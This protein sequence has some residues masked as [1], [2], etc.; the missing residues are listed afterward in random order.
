MNEVVRVIGQLDDFTSTLIR[1]LTLEATANLIE[2][3]PVDTGWA[4]ANWVPRIGTPFE[5]VSGTREQ[6]E[7]GN[8]VTSDR[9]AGIAQIAAQYQIRDGAVYITNN[10]PYIIYLNEGRSNQAPSG[11]V[12]NAISRAIR[13]VIASV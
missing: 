5:S 1:R 12:Q 6:A 8:V 10:V 2:D 11:Y 13:R 9:E 3:T 4:R 7:A